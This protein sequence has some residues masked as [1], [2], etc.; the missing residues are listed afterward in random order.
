MSINNIKYHSTPPPSYSVHQ[1]QIP[2]HP[3]PLVQCPSTSNTTPP[4]PPRTV[5]INIKYHTTPPPS[6][7]V[8]QHQ[9][10]PHPTPL[11]P[12]KNL[13]PTRVLGSIVS[14]WGLQHC[15]SNTNTTVWIHPGYPIV[16]SQPR[17]SNKVN[18]L[19]GFHKYDYYSHINRSHDP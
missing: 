7:S 15:V 8:H 5:S 14:S 3:T 11:L 2:P 4:H 1:H 17:L 19:N 13:V 12:M 10:P 6:Y 16:F 9:I 18:H